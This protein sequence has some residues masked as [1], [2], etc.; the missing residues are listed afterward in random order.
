M[1][2][3]ILASQN[4]G[5]VRAAEGEPKFL[6]TFALNTCMGIAVS[7]TY[8]TPKPADSVEKRHDRFMIHIDES[9]PA[10]KYDELADEVKKAQAQGLT[11]L[12]VHFTAPA[13]L[14]FRHEGEKV[15]QEVHS[16]QRYL[17]M[18]FR[19][20]VGSDTSFDHQPTIHWY[21]YQAPKTLDGCNMALFS[22]RRVIVEKEQLH[23]DSYQR[24]PIVEKPWDNIPIVFPPATPA[25]ADSQPAAA[26]GNEEI[27]SGDSEEGNSGGSEEGKSGGSEEGK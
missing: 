27:K 25:P 6:Y 13:P 1:G 12:H 7:G 24:W 20:L 22:D 4:A 14:S 21:P 17:M 18:R 2:S 3:Y 19:V 9:E 8:P 5:V 15:V 26:S 11:D 16:L 10:S 23:I